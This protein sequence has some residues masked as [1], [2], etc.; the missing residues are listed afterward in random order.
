MKMLFSIIMAIVVAGSKTTDS[1]TSSTESEDHP[2]GFRNGH[3]GPGY[4]DSNDQKL[5]HFDD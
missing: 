5:K 1:K 2:S 3:S 4:Y